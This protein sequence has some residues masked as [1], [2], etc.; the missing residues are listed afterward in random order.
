[1]SNT[2]FTFNNHE[3]TLHR[4][5]TFNN[6]ENLQAWD[7]ADEL[8]IEHAIEKVTD[9]NIQ[10]IAVINDQFGAV[11]TSLTRHFGSNIT[12][13][14]ITD[15]I[16]AQKAARNN[17]A[18]NAL[19]EERIAW[20]NSSEQ[21]NTKFDLILLK[22][23]KNKGYL[24]YL[25]GHIN[26]QTNCPIVAFGKTKE[27]HTSTLNLFENYIGPTTTSLAKKKSRL[28]FSQCKLNKACKKFPVS[29]PLSINEKQLNVL[30]H[31]NVFSRD[32]LDIGARAFIPHL[33]LSD[34]QKDIIDL[35]CGNGVIGLSLLAKH[36]DVSVTFVDE[37]FMAVKSA[38]DNVK[39]NYPHQVNQF[40]FMANDCLTGFKPNQYDLVLCNPPFHQ[41]NTI[42]DHIAWQMFNDAKRVLRK[43]GE[44]RIVGNR[45][46]NYHHKLKRLFG[47]S[48][49][50]A[51]SN[52][53]VILSAIKNK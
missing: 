45:H 1:M 13:S 7:S 38:K 4:Y 28:I 18:E 2:Q 51:S 52:K 40:T 35:G 33:A 31:A 5:P 11:T 24:E 3:I 17:L 6:D 29:W 25:L 50:V 41:Q 44:L 21:I 49:L 53:F 12:I 32:S 36:N 22:I 43:G 19:E 14:H 20:L 39:L 27:I 34:E 30:N 10:N 47:N 48:T 42:T 23:T 15:S 46:L 37:S 26:T 9:H 8:A 16:I